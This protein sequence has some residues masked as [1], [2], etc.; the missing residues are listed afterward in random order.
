MKNN[1]REF[2]KFAGLAGVGL[3]GAGLPA[4][5]ASSEQKT[6]AGLPERSNLLPDQRFNM[7]GYAA[8]KLE[9][10]RIGHIGQGGRGAGVVQRLPQIEGAEIRALCDLL[11][12]RSAAAAARLKKIGAVDPTLYTGSEDAWKKV[13]ERDDIDLVYISTPWK[14]HTPI[15]VHAMN[16]GK[17]AVAEVPAALTI[18]ECWQLVEASEK[19]RRHFMMAQ[20]TCYDFF[21]ML[22]L[23]LARQGFF[24][25]IIH[26]EGAYLHTFPFDP[27]QKIKTWRIQENAARNG[28]LYPTHGIGPVCQAM[29]INCGDRLDFLVSVSSSDFRMR[30]EFNQAAM[31]DD[32]WKPVAAQANLTH[33]GNINTSAIGYHGVQ[34]LPALINDLDAQNPIYDRSNL[35]H[36][37]RGNYYFDA[38]V[39]YRRRLRANRV[40]AIFQLNVR[41]LQK[42]GRLQT[43]AAFPDAR[44][45]PTASS[46]RD[47]SSCRRRL[48]CRRGDRRLEIQMANF[49]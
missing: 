45:A 26:G 47:S 14:L 24:G 21:E 49:R 48:N 7:S 30:S 1:R 20:N 3:S 44:P 28:N 15:A 11:P 33:R 38:F 46:I 22:T 16:H 31:A 5:A 2:L 41:N 34:Q 36:G 23:N 10:V 32:F 18:D 29:N 37:F 40:G 8:P 9:K 12:E 42:G 17:H 25:D 27:K 13:C 43:V 4:Y 6:G 39:G 35:G 19:N